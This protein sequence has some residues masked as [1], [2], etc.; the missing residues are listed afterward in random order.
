MPPPPAFDY[1]AQL[2][3]SR[4]ATDEEIT[5]S[6]RQLARKWH[7]DKNPENVEESTAT[8]QKI[9]LA[10]E[11]LRDPVHRRR[12]DTPRPT[13]GY[14][15]A[16]N[17][18]R[19]NTNP[20]HHFDDDDEDDDWYNEYEDEDDDDEENLEDFLFRHFGG[21]FH[22]GGSSYG[23]GQPQTREEYIEA[24]AE[25]ERRDREETFIAREVERE[26]HEK[27]EKRKQAKETAMKAEEEARNNE[28]TSR[29][30]QEKQKQEAR[31]QRL[32]ATT[33][34]EKLATCL[35][36]EGCNKVPQKKK[37]KCVACRAK[38]GMLA[39]ECPYCALFL[40]Q[41]C[42][43]DS[44]K[45]RLQEQEDLKREAHSAAQPE[46]EPE[47][48][49]DQEDEEMAGPLNAQ[50]RKRNT[51]RGKKMNDADKL[52]FNCGEIGHYAKHCVYPARQRSHEPEQP[53]EAKAPADGQAKKG[54]DGCGKKTDKDDRPCLGCGQ[55]GHLWKDCVHLA[56]PNPLGPERQDENKPPA[57]GQAK[58][59]N[60]AR[61]KKMDKADKPC[62][63]CGEIGHFAKH[64]VNSASQRP[65]GSNKP[66]G[67]QPQGKQP[68]GKQP[69]G[70]QPQG[71]LAGHQ[72]HGGRPG[73]VHDGKP[74]NNPNRTDST[75]IKTNGDATGK[76]NGET[77]AKA[78]GETPA[79]A[80]A[81]PRVKTSAKAQEKHGQDA[82]E[83]LQEKPNGKGHGKP[84]GKPHRKPDGNAS[85]NVGGA[86][87]SSKV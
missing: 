34:D 74:L 57:G 55:Y 60:A 48:E 50:A 65:Q 83:K 68:Q 27:A 85:H 7:P 53:D 22:F 70:K 51:G 84:K 1:Y 49:P 78:N 71:K 4:T 37:F 32:N 8:F 31:W 26:R 73:G 75:Y 38:R 40:C 46:P 66:Q 10:Y 9:Q 76:A 16:Y 42:V 29:L 77:P 18:P 80:K 44:A 23:G 21:H 67:K 6:Y 45:K 24:R 39:F 30:H 11:T 82:S 47:S 28:R 5:T 36:S 41:L 86:Q 35:H 63:N 64:C 19:A 2:E 54:N 81:E 58:K 79:K 43:N 12:Y 14:P 15:P 17:P 3:V 61:V 20:F 33:K 59:G 62:F 52:C 56:R 25:R 72:K 87:T 13:P 69:Q